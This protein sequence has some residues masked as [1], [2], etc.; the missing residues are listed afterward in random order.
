MAKKKKYVYF[1]GGA[2]TEGKATMKMLLGGKGAN[3]AEMCSM[4]LPVPAGFTISTET[5]E[6]Y[7]DLGHKYPAEVREQTE[8]NIALLE[9]ATGKTF[10]TGPNP[11]L[12]AIRVGRVSTVHADVRRRGARDGAP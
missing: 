9:K 3:L 7:Y 5:C 2:K 4:G 11:L 12:R 1:F 6:A 8:A 10:G